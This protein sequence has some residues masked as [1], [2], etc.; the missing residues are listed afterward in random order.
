MQASGRSWRRHGRYLMH[1]TSALLRVNVQNIM[2]IRH[3]PEVGDRYSE[4]SKNP[5]C[6]KVVT[7]D[8]YN[9]LQN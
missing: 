3:D 6:Q 7:E 1:G 8:D 9:A 4:L 5:E 2:L